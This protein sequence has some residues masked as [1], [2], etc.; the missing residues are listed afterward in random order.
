MFKQRG[1]EAIASNTKALDLERHSLVNAELLSAV[2]E[3]VS[4]KAVD[5]DRRL[6]LH[7]A[8][9]ACSSC[10]G[11]LFSKRKI[12]DVRPVCSRVSLH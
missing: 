12:C 10:E 3:R 1:N 11:C 7:P 8:Y 5:P 9:I 6:R 2:V 4:A